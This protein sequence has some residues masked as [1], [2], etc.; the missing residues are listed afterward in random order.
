MQQTLCGNLLNKHR[1]QDADGWV[2]AGRALE[3]IWPELAT[4][5]CGALLTQEHDAAPRSLRW[6][7]FLDSEGQGLLL[8][9]CTD[10]LHDVH[11]SVQQLRLSDKAKS[12]V[13]MLRGLLAFGLLRH[14]LQKRH[15]VDYGVTDR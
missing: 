14:C 6:M 11:E 5:I 4:G 15:N 13:L 8:Q 2:N 1:R 7:T 10:S 12:H 3:S 9:C